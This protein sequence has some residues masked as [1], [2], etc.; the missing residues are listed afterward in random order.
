MLRTVTLG[1][2]VVTMVVLGAFCLLLLLHL[3]GGF[4][5]HVLGLSLEVV[6]GEVATLAHSVRVVGLVDMATA[7]GHLGLTLVLVATVAH[8]LGI[9]LLVRVGASHLGRRSLR[10]A[11]SDLQLRAQ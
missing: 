10:S 11:L 5:G 9:G 7:R 1:V 3:L 8:V 6:L 2:R 4:L